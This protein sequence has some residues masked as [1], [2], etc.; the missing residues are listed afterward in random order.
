MIVAI[1]ITCI[2]A[3]C[4]LIQLSCHGECSNDK[5]TI[6]KNTFY[7]NNKSTIFANKKYEDFRHRSTQQKE[8]ICYTK[9]D[10]IDETI[11]QKIYTNDKNSK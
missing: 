4:Y 10:C 2:T 7:V 3:C 8:K 9:K 1:S 11:I 5:H 6:S